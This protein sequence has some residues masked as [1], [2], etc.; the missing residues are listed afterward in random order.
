MV[1]LKGRFMEYSVVSLDPLGRAR[2]F[3]ANEEAALLRLLLRPP[4]APTPALEE[5]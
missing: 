1:D 4:V 5:R 2:I 3:P